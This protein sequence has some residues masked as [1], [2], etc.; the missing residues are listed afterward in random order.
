VDYIFNT[1]KNNQPEKPRLLEEVDAGEKNIKI[2]E[3]FSF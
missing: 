1:L 3:D 2:G